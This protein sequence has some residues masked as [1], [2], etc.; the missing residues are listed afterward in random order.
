MVF[1]V[2]VMPLYVYIAEGELGHVEVV[3]EYQLT[4]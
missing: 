3:L 4:E 1:D 2:T